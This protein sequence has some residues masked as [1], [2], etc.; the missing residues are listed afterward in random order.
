MT[1]EFSIYHPQG[2]SDRPP[3]ENTEQEG[4]LF[5]CLF[6]LSLVSLKKQG[7]RKSLHQRPKPQTRNKQK[8]LPPPTKRQNTLHVFGNNNLESPRFHSLQQVIKIFPVLPTPALPPPST[9][10]RQEPHSGCKDSPT[11]TRVWAV[12]LSRAAHSTLQRPL[13]QP[14]L[15][16]SLGTSATGRD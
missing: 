9:A 5:V 2:V 15:R 12:G 7:T 13:L 8:T 6:F 1:A 4:C 14:L 11:A 16:G 3:K 10:C